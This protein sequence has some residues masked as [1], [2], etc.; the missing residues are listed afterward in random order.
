MSLTCDLINKEL[1]LQKPTCF[2]GRENSKHTD[3]EFKMIFTYL[4][5]ENTESLGKSNKGLTGHGLE[6]GVY[7]WYIGHTSGVF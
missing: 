6:F 5:N 3:S 7:F 2:I 4:S 1:S